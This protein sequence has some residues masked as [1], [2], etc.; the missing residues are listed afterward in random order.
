VEAVP[1]PSFFDWSSSDNDSERNFEDDEDATTE[2]PED[3]PR[4]E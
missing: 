1:S 4:L 2:T 3:S